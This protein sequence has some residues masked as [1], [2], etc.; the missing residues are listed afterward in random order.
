MAW[1]IDSHHV[2]GVAC[3]ILFFFSVEK[4]SCDMRILLISFVFAPTDL[5]WCSHEGFI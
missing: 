2:F 3:G 1:P 5:D 4:L